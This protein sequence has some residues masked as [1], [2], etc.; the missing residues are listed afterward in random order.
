MPLYDFQCNNCGF[1]E[2]ALLPMA[3]DSRLCPK[4]GGEMKRLPSYP[5]MVK[6]K[7]M[8]GYPARRKMV[9]GTAPYC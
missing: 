4:C 5:V 2:E 6:I 3:Q 7:G 9:N 1:I 8:G